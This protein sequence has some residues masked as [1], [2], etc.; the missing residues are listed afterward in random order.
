MIVKVNLKQTLQLVNNKISIIGAGASGLLSSIILAR[1]KFDVTIFEKNTKIGRKILATGNGKCNISNQNISSKNFFTTYP[2]F[3]TYSLAQFD[4]KKFE[5]FF[6]N[7]G[8]E[9]ISNEDGKVYP[10]SLQASSVVDVLVYEAKRVGVKFVLDTNITQIQYDNSTNLFKLNDKFSSNKLII[11]SGTKAMAKLGSS[12]SGFNFA[13]QFGHDIIEPFASLVQLCSS[14]KNIQNL[15]GVKVESSVELLID[16]QSINKSIGDVLFT[17]YGVSGNAILDI[18][19]EASYSLSLGSKVAIKIDLFPSI[20]KDNLITKLNKRI[21]NSNGKDKY[22][23]LE[24]FVHTK[25]AKYIIDNCGI[26]KE[27]INANEISKK[28]IN[29]ISYFMKNMKI[30]IN[31]TKD[32]ESAE[33]SAGGIDVSQVNS[34]SMES[35]LQ[36]DLYFTGEVLDVDGQCGGYNLHWAW[37]SGYVCANGIVKNYSLNNS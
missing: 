8:L 28:D 19:R 25:L 26:K 3:I 22:F 4:Y 29:T 31:D 6:N 37:A 9:L 18:S 33:V 14:D 32:F 34:R 7:L 35:N 21:A 11:S 2:D 17:S 15:S 23:W 30:N 12:D 1:A 20:N 10:M 5:E 24:G 16:N 36:K 13:K 27:K